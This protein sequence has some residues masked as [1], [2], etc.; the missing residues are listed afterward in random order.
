MN[1][2]R[3]RKKCCGVLGQV[4]A[5]H[6]LACKGGFVQR[7]ARAANG[8]FGRLLDSM[9]VD[10]DIS[11]HK[12]GKPAIAVHRS[13]RQALSSALMHEGKPTFLRKPDDTVVV[14]VAVETRN[15]FYGDGSGV[16]ALAHFE[17]TSERQTIRRMQPAL[18]GGPR[19]RLAWGAAE[20]V[21]DPSHASNSPHHWVTHVCH[22]GA[23]GHRQ[24][25]LKQ[26]DHLIQGQALDLVI[27]S[28]P[29]EAQPWY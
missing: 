17:S 10:L 25:S 27:D 6:V 7:H 5:N 18:A 29:R 26:L 24:T 8:E 22:E 23:A 2:I 3:F 14:W 15:V 9:R 12:C 19:P 20:P 11:A 1:S 16:D 28:T 21:S 13:N 4:F